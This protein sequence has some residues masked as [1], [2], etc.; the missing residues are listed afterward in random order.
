MSMYPTAAAS[1]P[2]SIRKNNLIPVRKIL[3]LLA[4]LLLVALFFLWK[5]IKAIYFSGVPDSAQPTFICIPTGASFDKVVNLLKK[6]GLINDESGFRWL[7]EQ[8]KYKRDTMRAGRFEIQPGWSNRDLISHLR[9]GKQAP[10]RVVLNNERFVEEIAGQVARFIEPD[11]L[12]ILKVLKDPVFLK[13]MGYTNETF[14]S[15]F[16]PNTY[17]MYWNTDPK[18]FVKRMVKEHDAFWDKNNRREKARALGL[19]EAQVYTLASIVE[20]ETNHNPEKPTIAGV[21]L[22]RLKIGMKLQADPTSVFATRDFAT[23]R[24]TVYHT[25][26]DSPYNTYMY[27]GLPPGPISMASIPSLDAV[28]NFED[29]DYLYF[30]AKPDESGSHAF[31]ATFAAH[32]VNAER[33]QAFLRTRGITIDRNGISN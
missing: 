11:S 4:A 8:M 25:T 15:A 23:R 14:I 28:L 16:I 18:A 1:N 12:K 29:H 26:F 31:A 7:S 10:V 22:N 20:R 2:S 3:L 13:E 19:N 9:A 17:E 27:A 30:C 5:P 24:V 33:F 32:K 21:Y 6:E